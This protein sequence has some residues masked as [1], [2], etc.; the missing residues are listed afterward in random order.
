MQRSRSRILTTHTGSLPR[1]RELTR[2][3]AARARG[4]AVERPKSIALGVRRCGRSCASSAT[5]VSTSAI[6]ASSSAIPSFSISRLACPVWAGAGSGHRVPMWSAIRISSAC[7]RSAC[8]QNTGLGAGRA[9][10]AIGEVRYLDDRAINEECRHFK[11]V[12]AE[13][14]GAFVEP[15]MSAP[16]PGILAMAVRNEHY[17]TLTNYL[18]ALG[19]ALA[20]DTR[21][22][23]ATGCC[24]RSML[25]ISRSNAT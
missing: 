13:S 24:C 20:V 15:F 8:E 23:C 22:S 19:K 3:Y 16:S 17:D 7:G 5:Q 18:A 1:P 2:L 25:P 11:A 4:E 21:P 12:L 6:T 14:P 10:K 9:P